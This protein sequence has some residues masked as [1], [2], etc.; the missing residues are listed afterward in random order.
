MSIFDLEGVSNQNM[1]RQEIKKNE[2]QEKLDKVLDQIRKKY[3][4]GAIV[5]GSLKK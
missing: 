3:G 4:D 2:K 1:A 5:R